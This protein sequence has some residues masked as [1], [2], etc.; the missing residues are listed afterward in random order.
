MYLNYLFSF[1]KFVS[2][3]F[4]NNICLDYF[5]KFFTQIFTDDTLFLRFQSAFLFTSSFIL[6]FLVNFHPLRFPIPTNY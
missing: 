4:V 3:N 2:P 5:T 6:Y 1:L